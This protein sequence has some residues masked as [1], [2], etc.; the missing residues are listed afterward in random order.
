[1]GATV[2]LRQKVETRFGAVERVKHVR[3]EQASP[4][5]VVEWTRQIGADHAREREARR[6]QSRR[7]FPVTAA[8]VDELIALFGPGQVRVSQVSEGGKTLG[9]DAKPGARVRPSVAKSTEPSV[10]PFTVNPPFVRY[11]D[12]P[13]FQDDPDAGPAP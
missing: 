6:E 4:G 2:Q 3:A 13:A 8:F 1:M 7:D 10:G 9:R 5:E 12:I 11:A